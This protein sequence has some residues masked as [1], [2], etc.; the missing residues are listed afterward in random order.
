VEQILAPG[1]RDG[2]YQPDRSAGSRQP[3]ALFVV[4]SEGRLHSRAEAAISWEEIAP[5]ALALLARVQHDGAAGHVVEIGERLSVRVVPLN[6]GTYV[7]MAEHLR[8]RNPI[9]AFTLR[10]G[11]TKRESEVAGCLLEGTGTAE[12][13]ER[14]GISPATVVLHVKRILAKTGTRTRVDLVAFVAGLRDQ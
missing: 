9:P 6:D 10:H 14:L 7:V 12:I 13:A 4:D 3:P 5:R 2:A 11:L 1:C 8:T